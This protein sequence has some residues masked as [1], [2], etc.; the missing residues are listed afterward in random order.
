MLTFK[1]LEAR[2]IS[3]ENSP[4]PVP[5][6]M[7]LIPYGGKEHVTFDKMNM[8]ALDQSVTVKEQFVRVGEQEA[9]TLP[10]CLTSYKEMG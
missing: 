8:V 5:L 7:I 9:L 10:G 4:L 1:D 2:F 6:K 3:M